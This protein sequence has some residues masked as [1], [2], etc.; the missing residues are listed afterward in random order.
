MDAKDDEQLRRSTVKPYLVYCVME[1]QLSIESLRSEIASLKKQLMEERELRQKVE[2]EL[3]YI[4]EEMVHQH[5]EISDSIDYAKKIQ[6]AILPPV[7]LIKKLLPKSF[8]LY[9]PKDV[10]SGDFYYVEDH[11]EKVVFAAVDCTGHGVPGA[12]MSV[13]GFEYIHQAV[14][15]KGMTKPSDIL[16]YLD[17]GVNNKLR[18]TVEPGGIRDGM[19]VAVCCIDYKNGKLQYAGA[20]NSLYLIR[21]GELEEIKP[22]KIPIGGDGVVDEFTNHEFDVQSGD[23]IYLFSDGYADQFGGPRGKKFKYRQF[24][25]TLLSMQQLTMPEQHEK[26]NEVFHSWMGDLEQVDDVCIVGVRI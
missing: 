3:K 1:S 4:N 6:T 12:L 8:I 13:V 11:E 9:L 26:L 16:S 19:D 2:A 25:E 20:Y 24:K 23:L 14:K 5:K 7:P 10:V 15:E 22:D 18:Q 21:N 17:W